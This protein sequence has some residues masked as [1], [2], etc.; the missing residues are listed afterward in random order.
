MKKFSI[1]SVLIFIVAACTCIS[2][3]TLASSFL[4][5]TGIFSGTSALSTPQQNF[6]AISMCSAA[7][8]EDLQ[9]QKL[10]LQSQGA[11]GYIIFK[12]NEYYLLAS[13]YDNRPDAELVKNNLHSQNVESEILEL[14][15]AGEKFSGNFAQQEKEVL[16]NCLKS[17][18][19][20]YKLL[21][22]V[23]ISLDTAVF[24]LAEAKLQCNNIYSS[25]V[26]T[27]TN[28]ESFFSDEALKPLADKLSFNTKVL[29]KLTKEEYETETQNFSS[30]IKLT[31]FRLLFDK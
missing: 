3:A 27:K 31:Y 6:Y 13:L 2:C 11:A 5:T 16:Q 20:T 9:E 1:L 29:E 12:D 25:A 22:D 17:T 24:S 30:L 15:V 18:A 26:A 19:T 8:L 28:F 10:Q 7:N 14:S 4:L 23:A 21:Y